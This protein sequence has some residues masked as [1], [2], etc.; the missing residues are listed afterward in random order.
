MT[1]VSGAFLM[2]GKTPAAGETYT[3]VIDP[4]TALEEIVDV[5]TYSSGNT[6]AI[7]RG[8]DGSTDVGHS[9]GAIVRHMVVGRD[10][11]EAN[12]H[13]ENTTTAHGLT[14]A[15]VVKTTD[16]GAVTSTMLLDG[17]ILNADINASA[18]IVDTKLATISTASK[19][20]N[21]ATTAASANT[22]SAIV[23]RDA[24]GNFTAGTVTATLTGNVTGNVTGTVSGNAGTVTN[25]VYTTDTGTV[26][27]TMILDGTIL[28]ADINA[29]ADIDKTK[30]SGTAVTVADTGTV[31]S[32]MIA[33][34]TI[35][36]A[37]VNAAAALAYSKLAL[38]GAIVSSDI[39]ND[40]ILNVD[41][42]TAAAI[43]ATKIAGTAVTQADTGTVTSTMLL[44]GTILDADINA[45]AA[46]D[47]TK[48]L[49]VALTAADSGTITSGNIATGTIV[50]ANINNNA[51]IDW[52]KLGI[53]STVDSTEIGY[54]NGVTSAIQTQIDSKLATATATSTYAPLASPALTGVPTAPTAAANTN[55][56]QVATTAFV[57]TELTDLIGGAPG[58]LD[59]LNE[60]AAA[61]SNDASYS[62]T[63]TTALATKLPLAGGTMTGAIAMG[64]S[65]ITG[66]GD[67]TLAQ[68]VSTK[69]YSD[70][71][72]PLTGGT[73][74]GALAMGTNKI[75]GL[76]TPTVS[77]DAATKDY[78]DLKLPLAGGALTGAL[79][80]GANK[81]TGLADPTLAQDAVTKYYADAILVGAPG[82]LTGPITSVGAATAVASQTGTGS[83][84]VMDTSPTLVT[85]V[86]GVA[87][88]TSINATTIPSTKTLVVTT[89]KLS[90][91]AATTSAELAGVISDETGTGALVFADTPTLVTPVL[92]VATATS[93]NATVIPSTKTLVATDSTTYVVPSQTGNNGKFLTTDGTTSSWGASAGYNAPT[94]GTTAI[95]SGATVANV[96]ALTINSTTIP[97]S[98]TLVKTSDTLAVH[99]ATTSAQLAGVIS[100]ETGTGALVFANT[101]TLVTPNIGAATGTSLV[102]SGDLTVNGTTTTINSTEITIDDKNLVLG[103]VE[104][105]TDA[106]ADG[107]GITLKGATDKTLNWVDATDAWTSSEHVNL[108]SGKE[109]KVNGTSLKDV[110]ETLAN[111]TLTAPVISY[112]TN[113]GTLTLPTSTGTV[114]LTSDITITGSS[115]LSAFAATTSAELAGVV[116]DETGTGAL[117]FANTP[118]LVTPALGAATATSINTLTVGLGFGAVP[119][120]TVLG[121]NVLPA[122]VDGDR[123]IAIG[124]DSMVLCTGGYQNVAI[125]YQ[126]MRNNIGG[127]R[128][129]GVGDQ[130]LKNSTTYANTAV[131]Y[132][133]MVT[134]TTGHDNVGIGYFATGLTTTG[135]FN[136][137]VGSESNYTVSTG[138]YNTA[139]GR[140]ALNQ[141]DTSSNNS[142]F[143]TSAGY[144]VTGAQNTMLG[145]SAG[146]VSTTGSNNTII[147]YNA[148]SST[149]TASNEMTMGNSSVTAFRIPGINLTMRASTY[150]AKTAA[151]TFASGDE[152][153]MFSMNNAATQQFNIPTDATFNFAVGTE[154]KVFWLT[155]AGQP[156][157]GAV[158]PGTTVVISTGATSATPKLRVANSVATIRKLAANSWIV[159]DDIS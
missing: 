120:N 24:S 150:T 76:G 78:A 19:V 63:I 58:A 38:A 81:I 55:T 9:A 37:D 155:G 142:C 11:Q 97:T 141:A 14:I 13:I 74:S 48:I 108:A 18:G 152:A 145:S 61:L 89:D 64:T 36:N 117:V 56:T 41:I 31:T 30:I 15:N 111:K 151:Y 5:G 16:T 2:G 115:K 153:N 134:N 68:D 113:T 66:V 23:A 39:A 3:V 96:D 129:V 157:I 52:T 109:F 77:T 29:A 44:N 87:T 45:S 54:V 139:V 103:S 143:G 149:T 46:I 88:A 146:S 10:L 17:T 102:L 82:N 25:G 47:K 6:L 28:N 26:T 122:N 133:A 125:G 69:A 124:T 140:R 158:T 75:T 123:N 70:L 136:T 12:N 128:N 101:P 156:T 132:G 4:D 50:N 144:A 130:A 84:F 27:S 86:L 21:S 127:Y 22:A 148:Q 42:N 126:S 131:G 107:G 65:K 106:G 1:V 57:Q 33:D 114:A 67:P 59:T 71:K 62:T 79:A 121:T 80:M 94:L 138:S 73:L 72:L 93:I 53:S 104:T 98:A 49:G 147:G 34:G 112:I 91:L 83:K 110:T 92:G 159:S 135:N 154:F 40:T 105:P 32:T 116:S 43:A 90:V 51:A 99:A 20:S 119:L 95:N 8:I 7:T 118:T 100:D 85:P 60:L 35:V 137:G